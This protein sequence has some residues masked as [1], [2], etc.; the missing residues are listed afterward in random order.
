VS[1]PVQQARLLKRG[2]KVQLLDETGQPASTETI[3]FVAPSV[4]DMTQTVLAKAAV[5]DRARTWRPDQIVRARV[6]WSTEPGL[7]V[8]VVSVIRINGQHFVYAA[9]TTPQ[10]LV[11]RQKAVTLGAVTANDYVVLNGLS[12]GE[13]IIVSGIQKI[14]DGMPVQAAGPPNKTG[15]LDRKLEVPRSHLELRRSNLDQRVS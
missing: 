8:P 3:S 11:A 2:L 10:G 4:D 7:T 5:T 1:V 15:R 12:A 14:G 13:Q 9:E 6:V